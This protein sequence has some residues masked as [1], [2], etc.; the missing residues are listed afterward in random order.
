MNSALVSLDIGSQRAEIRAP[1]T[2]SARVWIIALQGDGKAR[3]IDD[4]LMRDAR[5]VSD[6]TGESL[7]P[8]EDDILFYE[9]HEKR[10]AY[11]TTRARGQTRWS[12]DRAARMIFAGE[13]V[14]AAREM[15]FLSFRGGAPASRTDLGA[16][17][18]T[19]V[20][21]QV[22]HPRDR[23]ETASLCSKGLSVFKQLDGSVE[24]IFYRAIADTLLGEDGD[25]FEI[26]SYLSR[27]QIAFGRSWLSAPCKSAHQARRLVELLAARQ[28][29]QELPLNPDPAKAKK[30][31]DRRS[32][33]R[34]GF[35]SEHAVG[36]AVTTHAEVARDGYRQLDRR[37]VLG[38]IPFE[39]KRFIKLLRGV[40]HEQLR[41][42]VAVPDKKVVA[43]QVVEVEAVLD[44]ELPTALGIAGKVARADGWTTLQLSASNAGVETPVV[45]GYVGEPVVF[46]VVPTKPGRVVLKL[47][48]LPERGTLLETELSFPVY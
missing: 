23:A 39:P 6:R 26:L 1:H 43:G 22:A 4:L 32:P 37:V 13:A 8:P 14:S 27:S 7:V 38:R 40:Q 35:S 30:I 24:G 45:G 12:V 19:R 5:W 42:S 2:P 16:P 31:Q 46:R 9:P 33:T 11:A 15:L 41:P 47:S 17:P 18:I 20:V 21:D 29:Q 48:C 44:G 10:F 28:S 25:P 3:S 34:L 36:L